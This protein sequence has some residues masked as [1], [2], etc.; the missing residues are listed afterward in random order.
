MVLL[1]CAP[2]QALSCVISSVRLLDKRFLL[3]LKR[4]LELAAGCASDDALTVL[5]LVAALLF[6]LDKS[7]ARVAGFLIKVDGVELLLH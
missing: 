7:L 2:V 4:Q 3:F 5:F 6:H 1:L